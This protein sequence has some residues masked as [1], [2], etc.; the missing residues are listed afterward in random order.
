MAGTCLFCGSSDLRE[1]HFDSSLKRVPLGLTRGARETFD[2]HRC[3]N[4]GSI[5]KFATGGKIDY[6]EAPYSSSANYNAGHNKA[7]QTFSYPYSHDILSAFPESKDVRILEIGCGAGW[8]A[9]Y[10]RHNGYDDITLVEKDPGYVK[11]LQADGFR[12][13]PDPPEGEQFDIA[14]SVGLL[15]HI[16]QPV[17]WLNGIMQSHIRPGGVFINQFPNVDSLGA[18][19]G[20]GRWDML[21]EPGH[22]YMPSRKGL[23]ARFGKEYELSF[24][25]S[26]I[27][28]RGR[29]PGFPVRFAGLEATWLAATEKSAVARGLNRLLWTAI[30]RA[31]KGETLT[32]A[33]R[34]V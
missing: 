22:I 1:Y 14:I 32:A 26:T 16:D 23:E 33:L 3:R 12:V 29:I 9:R 24:F 10:M 30:D 20:L 4:C 28:T 13:L 6:E 15:E 8:L 7:P 19:L 17:D 25:T 18:R 27:L 21:F 2:G 11:A 5:E 34:R 31:G